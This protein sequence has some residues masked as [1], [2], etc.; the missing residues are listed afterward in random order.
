MAKLSP[1]DRSLLQSIQEGLSGVKPIDDAW[2]VMI[3]DALKKKPE[4]FK[5]LFKGKGQMF[6][7]HLLTFLFSRCV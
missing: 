4:L 6:G 1:D 5:T 3:I 2:I 7:K